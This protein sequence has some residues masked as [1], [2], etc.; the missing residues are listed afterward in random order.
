VGDLGGL[1]WT[2]ST[3]NT[4]RLRWHITTAIPYVNGKPHIGHALE[5]VLTDALAR[6]RWLKG[7]DVRF[8][9]GTDENSLKN[10]QAA[11]REGIPTPA[12]VDRNAAPYHSLI[13]RPWCAI[14]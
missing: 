4:E 12:H 6:Y 5:F 9:T 3:Q 7:E 14:L 11:E 2:S 1:S 13:C 10:V 8:L